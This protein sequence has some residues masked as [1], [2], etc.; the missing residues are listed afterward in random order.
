ME[1]Y[2]N[3]A[4]PQPED[5]ESDDDYVTPLV[6]PPA[7]SY[8]SE[9]PTISTVN[10]ATKSDTEIDDVIDGVLPKSHFIDQEFLTERMIWDKMYERYHVQFSDLQILVAPNKAKWDS[11]RLG[12]RTPLHLIDRFSVELTAERR[13]V[14]TTD[15]N[16]PAISM[17][18]NLPHLTLH[19][20]HK[21]VEVWLIQF[22]IFD[23][24]VF[25]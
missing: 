18:G 2:L 15:P 11:H 21:K 4:N 16:Y 5:Y 12:S 7:K 14:P 22:I 8:V 19:I 9:K 24:F 10:M 1:Q 23:F 25:S 3:Q 6:T 13:I 17:T 20:S